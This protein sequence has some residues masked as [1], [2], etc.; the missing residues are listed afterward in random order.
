MDLL[1]IRESSV[2]DTL[3]ELRR[4]NFVVVGG[5][6]VN[7]YTLPRFSLDCDLVVED[8][9][10]LNRMEPVLLGLRYKKMEHHTDS[11]D[12]F[13]RYEKQLETSFKISIDVLIGEV[14]DRQTNAHIPAGWIF[15]N[16]SI[17]LLRGKTI[18]EELKLRIID[19]DALFVLKMISCRS[20]DVRDLFMLVPYLK[21]TE[22]I[23][24]EVSSRC[25][26]KE[27]LGI[28][29]QKVNSK[30]FRD[31][32]QGVYGLIDNSIYERNVKTILSLGM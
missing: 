8:K 10:E 29:R 25:D 12:D 9:E 19:V 6:A 16:S 7:A 20:T 23:K 27:R 21:N 17:R 3:K 4:F 32:L 5:Y 22:F 14:I 2:F 1:Q 24:Q 26:L 30:K 18:A 28:I 31:G 11:N 13:R 15:K